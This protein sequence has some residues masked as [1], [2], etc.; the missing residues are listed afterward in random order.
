MLDLPADQRAELAR[1]LILSLEGETL[2]SDTD[3]AWEAEIE[4]RLA[5]LDRGE[6]VP[7]DWREAVERI[8][9]WLQRR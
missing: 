4:R 1:E 2:D 5:A 9:A 3:A 6:V 8:G 7:V